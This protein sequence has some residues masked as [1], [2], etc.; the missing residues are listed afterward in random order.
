MKKTL[1]F[2]T[3]SK[4]LFTL[5]VFCLCFNYGWGQQVIG[6]FPIMDGGLEGQTAGNLKSQGSSAKDVASET[7]S[8]STTGGTTDEKI[9]DTPADARTGI[10]SCQAQL[11]NDKDNARLQVPS[12][13]APNAMTI[14]TEYTIQFFYKSPTALD[15]ANLKPGIYLN[16]TSSGKTTNKTDI[17]TFAADTW[18][19]AHGTVTTGSDF[20]LSNWAVVRIG[21]EKGVDKP[22]ISFDDFVVYAGEYDD[23][24][25]DAATAG[26]YVDNSGTGTI[27][28]TAPATGVDN[29][30]Y[31]VLKYSS[32]PNADNDPNQNGIYNVGN[33][34]TNGTEGLTGT[35][36]Y[37]GT[38]TSFT[39][40]HVA[41]TFYKVY[42]VD[43]AFNYSD[44]L[45][46]SSDATASVNDVF[47]SSIS[48]YPNPANDFV[49]ISTDKTIT[50]VEVYN[51]IGKKV[52]A[53]SSLRNDKLDV[54]NLA[55]G[56]YVLKVISNELV[57]SRKIIIK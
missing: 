24:M 14:N 56:V 51:L 13:V 7:W 48:I 3:N 54:S 32:N 6:E 36:A 53:A 20:N 17:G 43:K 1:L 30:G 19:K 40:T 44:E 18:I 41:G 46:I 34:T 4:S 37:I 55:K 12:T 22:L 15:D 21:G 16:N 57:G 42:T 29:G 47:S 38:G 33:T 49:K 23:A 25:P 52:I 8:I 2:T 11:N 27:S 45:Q 5:L 28:W 31:V 35:V 39:E 26:S 10:F 9:L 50:G